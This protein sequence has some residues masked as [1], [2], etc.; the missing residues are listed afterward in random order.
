MQRWR[1]QHKGDE[2]QHDSGQCGPHTRSPQVGPSQRTTKFVEQSVAEI[3]GL[4]TNMPQ[5]GTKLE[6]SLDIQSLKVLRSGDL[7][8]VLSL[9]SREKFTLVAGGGGFEPPLTGS[10]PVV[11]PL[12]DPPAPL[13]PHEHTHYRNAVQHRQITRR[14]SAVSSQ[15]ARTPEENDRPQTPEWRLATIRNGQVSRGGTSSPV[16]PPRRSADCTRAPARRASQTPTHP[17]AGWASRE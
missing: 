6:S 2:G 17:T 12:D 4:N 11:L 13:L 10:E 8:G 15:R 14:S 9:V 16:V 1:D 3:G 7:Q 5:T